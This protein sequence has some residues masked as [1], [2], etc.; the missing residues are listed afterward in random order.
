M[1]SRYMQ[2]FVYHIDVPEVVQKQKLPKLALQQIVEN[3]IKHGF[4]K[5]MAYME[6]RITGNYSESKWSICI[7]DNGQGFDELA[8]KNIYMKAETMK[9]QLLEQDRNIE[10]TLGGMG[11]V[12]LYLRLYFLYKTDMVFQIENKVG[13]ASVTIGGAM[14]KIEKAQEVI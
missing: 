13:G 8:L 6:I 14:E 9:H 11:L 12:N 2:K 10:L 7:E 3:S 4:E 1:K 5:S